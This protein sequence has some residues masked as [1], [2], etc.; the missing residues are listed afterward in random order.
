M[1]N[2][3][4]GVL[5]GPV[6]KGGTKYEGKY[7]RNWRNMKGNL[8]RKRLGIF[9]WTD[10]VSW[11]LWKHLILF[12]C[13]GCL[14]SNCL[15]GINNCKRKEEEHLREEEIELCD[16]NPP[17][18]W[19]LCGASGIGVVSLCVPGQSLTSLITEYGLL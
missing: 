18:S 13:W 12:W 3:S 8:Y 4:T 17:G 15:L 2:V 10:I 6:E 5:G 19:P 11:V 9:W 1:I 14:G 16:K 7:E